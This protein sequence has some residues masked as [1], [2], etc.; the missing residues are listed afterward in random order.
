[1]F[2]SDE[3]F[4]IS[5]DT[6]TNHNVEGVCSEKTCN[7]VESHFMKVEFYGIEFV[8]GLCKRHY[9]LLEGKVFLESMVQDELSGNQANRPDIQT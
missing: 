9:D 2:K 3:T 7:T 4:K 8:V 5:L 1:M 6:I